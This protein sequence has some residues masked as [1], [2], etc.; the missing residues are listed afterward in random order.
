[1]PHDPALALGRDHAELVDADELRDMRNHHRVLL[2]DR[3][4]PHPRSH[5]PHRDSLRSLE[6]VHFSKVL[7]SFLF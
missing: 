3:F 1:V 2:A 5:R 7:P 4:L 6:R